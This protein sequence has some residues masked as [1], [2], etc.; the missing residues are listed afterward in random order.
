MIKAKCLQKIRD[1]NNHILGYKLQDING[2][3]REFNAKYI[4]EQIQEI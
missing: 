4:K 2:N 1:K 3:I